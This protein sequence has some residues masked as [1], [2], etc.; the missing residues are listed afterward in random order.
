MKR[1]I[2]SGTWA[3]I[4]GGF[5][6]YLIL[7][8]GGMIDEPGFERSVAVSNV[9]VE[10]KNTTEAAPDFSLQSLQGETVKLSDMRGKTVILNFWTSWCPP[11]HEEI[12]ELEK[13]QADYIKDHPDVVLLGINLTQEDHGEEKIKSFVKANQMTFP[14]LLDTEGNVARAYTILTIPSTYIVDSEGNIKQKILGPVTKEQLIE[15]VEQ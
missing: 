13:F 7:T 4:M 2:Q 9:P 11:C 5:G 3:F 6:F 8:S 1:W 12:P 15:A 14:V 10:A